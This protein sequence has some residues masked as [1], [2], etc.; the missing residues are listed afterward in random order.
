MTIDTDEFLA[1][2]GIDMRLLQQWIERQWVRPDRRDAAIILSE[3]DAARA[4]FIRDL[5]GDFGVNDEGVEIVLHLVDQIH[6]LRRVLT[7]LRSDMRTKRRSTVRRVQ[8]R[9]VGQI[10]AKRRRP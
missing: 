3:L 1:Q 5:K 8:V 4:R 7:E 9:K 6:G 2:S 10:T